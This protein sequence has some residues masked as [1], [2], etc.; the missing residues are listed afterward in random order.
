MV[1]PLAD[2]APSA[3]QIERVDIACDA[4]G[5]VLAAQ[6]PHF[7]DLTVV[8]LGRG[9]DNI[10]FLL[11]GEYVARFPRHE[12][13]ADLIRNEV[14]WVPELTLLSLL[15]TSAPIFA[16]APSDDFPWPWMVSRR[17]DGVPPVSVGVVD[18][19]EC[20][21]RLARFCSTFHA[22]APADAPFNPFRSVP[23]DARSDRLLRDLSAV[24]N[25]DLPGL[26]IDPELIVH[27]W[28]GLISAPAF[29]GPAQWIHGDLHPGNLL[30][31][32][33]H[34]TGVVD[35]GDLAAGDPAVDLAVAW[36]LFS[37]EQRETFFLQAG[38]GDQAMRSR[39]RAW[40]MALSLAVLANHTLAPWLVEICGH[41]LVA[42]TRG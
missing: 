32:G 1:E 6:A 19:A 42:A 26:N 25:A 41:A 9:W 33:G 34:L 17:I 18:S 39:S 8:E 21:L 10:V 11:G 4:V 16:G 12:A 40:A 15:P 23:L 3:S 36:Y 24:L 27:T 31:V 5:R 2:T 38:E 22:P 14:R 30:H 29:A 28:Q 35:F 20:A 37:A 7:A 13:A